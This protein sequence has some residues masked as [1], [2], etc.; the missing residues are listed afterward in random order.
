MNLEDDVMKCAE[1]IDNAGWS[2]M[3]LICIQGK[4]E[5]RIRGEICS[6][7]L[8]KTIP[9]SDIG[10]MVLKID[11]ICDWLGTPQR[12]TNPR[13]M[14]S[15]MEQ[16]YLDASREHSEVVEDKGIGRYGVTPFP[17]ALKS[18]AVLVVIVRYRQNSSIQGTIKGRL[19][20]DKEVSFRSALELMRMMQFM[21][22]TH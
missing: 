5:D 15:E 14:N 11:E 18:R 20:G 12:T 10:D 1:N 7:H 3:M 2:S 13:F 9:F 17:Q 16:R 6:Y 19:T 8:K 4:T 21:F 22:S